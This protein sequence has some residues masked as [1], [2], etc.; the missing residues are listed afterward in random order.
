MDLE[1]DRAR[2][3]ADR[4]KDVRLTGSR[5]HRRGDEA[6][7]ARCAAVS[8]ARAARRSRRKP[9]YPT[10][11]VPFGL[12]P[13]APP[14]AFPDRIRCEARAV[15]RQLHRRRV[16]RAAA[17]RACVRVRAGDKAQSTAAGVSIK[18]GEE[19]E[20]SAESMPRTVSVDIET[21]G[22]VNR[23]R[24][25]AIAHGIRRSPDREGRK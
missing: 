1:R 5:R 12:V 25:C 24:R 10:V 4:A 13:N 16:Q 23:Q 6:R 14:P 8:R 21:G 20:E 9:G 22:T 19:S 11:I 15:R 17:D 7:A 2:Y 18:S 3:E